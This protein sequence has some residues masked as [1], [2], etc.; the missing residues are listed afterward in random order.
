[1]GRLFTLNS[2]ALSPGPVAGTRVTLSAT[3]H[4]ERIAR[5]F[6]D[7]ARFLQNYV[8]R[9]RFAVVLEDRDGIHW[10]TARLEQNRLTLDLMVYR[11][12]LAPLEVG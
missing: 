9:T 11:G 1:M 4:P 12:T 6:P 10:W 7:F 3:L 8:A 5:D 2:I